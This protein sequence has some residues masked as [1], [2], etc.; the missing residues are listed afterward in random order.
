MALATWDDPTF[1][2]ENTDEREA[3]G[4]NTS[5][6]VVDSVAGEIGMDAMRKVVAATEK[7]SIAYQG[8]EKP[9]GVVTRVDSAGSST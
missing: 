1:T 5:F 8:D 6:F 3:Y 2:E 4:Y 7:R 9:E